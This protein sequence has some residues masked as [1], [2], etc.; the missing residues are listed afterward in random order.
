MVKP[1]DVDVSKMIIKKCMDCGEVIYYQR[2]SNKYSKPVYCTGCKIEFWDKPTHERILFNLQKEFHK[3]KDKKVVGQMFIHLKSY[4]V[5]II[6]SFIRNKKIYSQEELEEKAT[7]GA[8][9]IIIHFLKDPNCKIHSSFGG[10]LK[11]ILKGILFGQK[12]HDQTLSLNL[13]LDSSSKKEFL[14]QMN[15]NTSSCYKYQREPQEVFSNKSS[16]VLNELESL[17]DT[18]S[19]AISKNQSPRDSILFLVGLDLRVRNGNNRTFSKM[20]KF[21]E[22]NEYRVKKN[23]AKMEELIRNLLMEKND[24]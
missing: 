17:V 7:D 1:T 22:H 20:Q 12:K 8:D 9:E 24:V 19:Q 23:L 4:A 21:L 5:N 3:T 6:K 16:T 13:P 11:D 10:W 15:T 2:R 18:V 14:D